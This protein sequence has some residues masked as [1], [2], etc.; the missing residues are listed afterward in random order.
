MSDTLSDLIIDYTEKAIKHHVADWECKAAMAEH[1]SDQITYK[2]MAR[3]AAVVLSAA[4]IAVVEALLH[5]AN[6][7]PL[8]VTQ[9]KVVELPKLPNRPYRRGG[10]LQRRKVITPR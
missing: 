9:A 5:H 7:A 8:R 1:L 4:K 3:A 2:T 6:G 10:P